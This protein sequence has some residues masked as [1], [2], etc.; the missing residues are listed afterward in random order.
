MVFVL[1]LPANASFRCPVSNAIA[2]QFRGIATNEI[3]PPLLVLR[4]VSAADAVYVDQRSLGGVYVA[5]CATSSTPSTDGRNNLLLTITTGGRNNSRVPVGDTSCAYL[6]ST[7]FAFSTDSTESG[8]CPTF[9]ASQ[10][11]GTFVQD[12]NPAIPTCTLPTAGRIPLNFQGTG[13][14]QASSEPEVIS[15]A[16]LDDDSMAVGRPF[17]GYQVICVTNW[18]LLDP[19]NMQIFFGLPCQES[20]F[21]A[22]RIGNIMTIGSW[23]NAG[24]PTA[25][26]GPGITTITV[27]MN[28]PPDATPSTTALPTPTSSSGTVPTPTSSSGSVPTPSPSASATANQQSANVAGSSAL[29]PGISAL[30]AILVIAIVCG[31]GAF[32][33]LRRGKTIALRGAAAFTTSQSSIKNIP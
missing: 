3:L 25:L 20:C 24:C 19:N 4:L 1:S 30:I 29:S 15:T 31:I 17:A 11:G 21:L 16:Y 8:L 6:G 7:P 9:E 2:S 33:Y 14:A 23:D 12:P 5:A 28:P 32:L 27:T 10:F 26:S 22:Q 18:N 13:T